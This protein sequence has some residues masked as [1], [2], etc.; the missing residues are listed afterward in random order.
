MPVGLLGRKIGM[1]QVYGENG[2]VVPVTV[3]EV[4]PCAVLQVKTLDR[5]GYQAV[6]LGFDDKLSWKDQ[7]RPEDQRNRSRAN[8]AERGHVAQLKSK[9]QKKLAE[10][11]VESRPKAN[12]EPK[13]YVREFRMDGEQHDVSVGQVITASL[14][15]GI[16]AVDVI[17]TTK[18]RG[19]TGAMKRHNFSGQGAAHGTKKVHRRVGAIGANAMNRGTSGM[20]KKGMRMAGRYGNERATVRNLTVVKVDAENNMLLVNGAVPG[21]NGGY[22]MVRVAK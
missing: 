9:R 8:R 13:K 18:G 1:T 22:L 15:D 4:G 16:K 3:L 21:P 5:D 14:F 19:F 6:Q 20:I 2:T 17:G 11:G 10:A 7:E 12:C